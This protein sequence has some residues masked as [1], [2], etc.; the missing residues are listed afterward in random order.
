MRYVAWLVRAWTAIYT[1]GLPGNQRQARRDEIESDLWE[2]CH[3]DPAAQSTALTVL[4]RLLRGL[5]DDLGWR[6]ERAPI[7]SL[8]LTCGAVLFATATITLIVWAG[9]AQTL[10]EPMPLEGRARFERPPGSGYAAPP[11]CTPLR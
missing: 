5:P 10:P 3:G 2:C 4:G 8:A 1:S 6:W 9:S 7:Q 11:R